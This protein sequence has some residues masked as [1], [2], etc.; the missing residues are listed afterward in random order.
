MQNLLF[1]DNRFELTHFLGKAVPLYAYLYH[2]FLHNFMGNQVCCILPASSY[3]Y[4]VAYSFAAGDM[5]T[6]VLCPKGGILHNWGQRDLTD[7]VDE[8]SLL[9][10]LKNL[11]AFYM[12]N[13]ELMCYGN[14]VKPLAYE[15][16]EVVYRNELYGRTYTAEQVV[17][18][19]FAYGE[20]RMQLFVNYNGEKKTVVW[21]GETIEIDAYSVVGRTF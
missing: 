8:E 14:M 9:I 21:Q 7:T 13:R 3:L 20:T 17:S 15:T 6:M 19:A 1:S 2:E 16:G 10:F 5:P 12:A 11:R 18:T 4:R